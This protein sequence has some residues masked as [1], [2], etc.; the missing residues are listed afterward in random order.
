MAGFHDEV[1]IMIQKLINNKIGKPKRSHFIFG[2]KKNRLIFVRGPF[3][4]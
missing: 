3:L 1:D 2:G 4:M